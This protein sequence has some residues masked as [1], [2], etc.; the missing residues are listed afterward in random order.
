MMIIFNQ[1]GQMKFE[2]DETE[3][4]QLKNWKSHLPQIQVDVWGR[5]YCFEYIFIPSGL[6]VQ[7]KVRRVDGQ[8]L[9]LTNYDEW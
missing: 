7:K 9:D 1:L 6:G 3:L 2:F 8:E 5:E 4:E